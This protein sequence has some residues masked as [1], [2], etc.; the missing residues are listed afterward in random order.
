MWLLSIIGGFVVW[1]VSVLIIF[2]IVE[3]I[4]YKRRDKYGWKIK[5]FNN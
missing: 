4:V 3:F 1:F 2:E 5:R